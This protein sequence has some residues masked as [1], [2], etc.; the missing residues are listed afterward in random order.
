MKNNQ[1]TFFLIILLCVNMRVVCLNDEVDGKLIEGSFHKKTKII[2]N[3]MVKTK[4]KQ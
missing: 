1:T 2:H 3:K 4:K